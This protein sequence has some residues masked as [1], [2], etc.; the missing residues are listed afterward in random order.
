MQITLFISCPKGVELLLQD[1][2]AGFGLEN[3]KQT[4]GGVYC[5]ADFEDIYQVCL[6]SR[7]ANRVIWM[8]EQ[9]M[10]YDKE[11]F[12]QTVKNISWPSCFS[13][14]KTFAVNF[15]GSN[16]FIKHTNY[17]GQLVKDAVV[18]HFKEELGERPDVDPRN[19]DVQLYAHVNRGKL[20]LGID[21]SGGS[22][23]QRGYRL[24]GSKAPLK[25]NLAA[26]LM[27]RSGYQKDD[28]RQLIDPMCGSGTL[29]IEGLLIRLSIAPNIDR[30]SFGFESL[31][32]HKSAVWNE[33]L[34]EA[35]SFRE[36]ALQKAAEEELPLAKG[37]DKDMR[38]L[39]A[40]NENA[41]RVGL[42][43]LVTFKKQALLDFALKTEEE[44][45]FVCNPPYGERLEERN[46]LFPLYQLL[47]EKIREHCQG[48]KAA[49]LSSDD[50]LLKAMAL[51]KSK[52][53]QFYNG[54]LP[55]QW[56]LFEIYKKDKQ[57][58]KAKPG[59]KDGD[60]DH[61][62]QK[63]ADEKTDSKFDQGVEMVANR[64]RKNQKNLKKWIKQKNIHTYRV[65][66]ADMPEYAFALDCYEDKYQL[67]EY[68][69]P[70]SVDKFAAF[71]RRQQFEK[72]VKQ[73]FNLRDHQL[74][75]KERKQQKG[76]S[77]YEKINESKNF[78]KVMEG[79]AQFIVNLQ[80]YLDTGL[81]LDHRP[82]RQMIAEQ[83]KGKRF[84]NLFSYTSAATVH[85]AIGG[86][87]SSVSVDMSK[88]YLEWS[89]R[90]FKANR[91]DLKRHQLVRA[92][93]VD[94]LQ[95]CSDQFDLIFLDPP[96]FSNSKR[97]EGTLDVQ[98]DQVSLIESTMA[99]LDE[100]GVLIFSN[101]R[102]D[103]KLDESLKEGFQVEN[104]S[105]KTIDKDFERNQKIHQ[106]WLIRHK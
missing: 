29:L 38:A 14:Q 3:F 12:Y 13:V 92:N 64:L 47:G 6:Y 53:Y 7:L 57:A 81:F 43:G 102:R 21:V 42:E 54:A 33:L 23:H 1:E 49:V 70:K 89:E 60:N 26:A 32:R 46:A 36:T 66:D 56:M 52:S 68:A 19:P 58:S 31:L 90:N 94:W 37:F 25:E 8:L 63:D 95:Q 75:F 50:H 5:S 34:N 86:A 48:S 35:R 15:K 96:S 76:K 18:D 69:P 4:V 105:Q 59:G 11:E 65:Y 83:A 73:V 98:R 44:I 101:N 74:H 17:G 67:T 62:W 104:I 77:Q 80:D 85:A 27:M 93:C 97:M 72:A 9:K 87:K 45:L 71:Q 99:L 51:Q 103:F 24:K 84:L 100:E 10:V 79:Q 40:A 22:L 88:T 30:E 28:Q 16:R 61:I 78:F 91:L 82:V 55:A 106:C 20:M 39:D 2:L 41:Q